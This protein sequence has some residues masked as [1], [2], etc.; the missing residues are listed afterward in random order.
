MTPT[1]N[2]VWRHDET[3]EFRRVVDVF[4]NRGSVAYQILGDG[5]E[6]YAT[7]ADFLAWQSNATRVWPI[8]DEK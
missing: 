7:K 2:E 3:G 1:P 5:R 4:I 6:W 8:G